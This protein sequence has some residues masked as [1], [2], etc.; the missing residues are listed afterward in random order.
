MRRL[1]SIL[2]LIVLF[3][4]TS[5]LA[6]PRLIIDPN[7][8]KSGEPVTV[9]GLDFCEG[10]QC[11]VV[12]VLL[13]DVAMHNKVPVRSGGVF[14]VEIEARTAPGLHSVRA[15]QTDEST[16]DVIESSADLVV[17]VGEREPGPAETPGPFLTG[18]R[19]PRRGKGRDH[20]GRLRRNRS[21]IRARGSGPD[22]MS[23]PA[24]EFNFTPDLKYGGRSVNA[25]ISPASSLTAIE[26]AEGSGLSRTSN[27]GATWSRIATF[28]MFRMEDVAYDPDDA[29]IVIA[30]TLHDG[31]V[32]SR[33]GIWQSTT[34][35]SFWSRSPVTYGCTSRPNSWG[36][37]T[38][39]GADVHQKIF[40]ANDCGVAY[41]NDSA[42][43]WNNIDPTGGAGTRF[44]D[45][46]ATRTGVD[47]VTAY[48]CGG[49][50][51]YRTTV[52]G[53]A[54]PSWTQVS[55]GAPLSD[56]RCMMAIS[57][58]DVNVVFLTI[59]SCPLAGS[60]TGQWGMRIFESDD[61]GASWNDLG[62]P[63]SSNRP[64]LVAA[65]PSI[66]AG[67]S[68]F[69]LY[70]GNGVVIYRQ[71]C[72]DDADPNTLDC[73]VGADTNCGD[74]ADDDGDG[75]VNEGCPAGGPDTD[76]NG[77]PDPESNGSTPSQC[78]NA[79]D[80]DGDGLVNDG[81]PIMER[82]DNGTHPD[83][84]NIAFDPATGCPT[85]ISNDGGI[86][87]STDCGLNWTDSNAGRRALQIYNT[88]GTVR[89]P[90]AAE[91]DIY[92]GTQ[93]NDWWFSL[94]NGGTWADPGCCEGF[95]GQADRRVP[96][97]GLA[98][99][100][101]TYKN[102]APFS[103]NLSPRGFSSFGGTFADPPGGN[104]GGPP[105]L[106]GNQRFAML[107][108]DR[109]CPPS[110]QLYIL[111][112]ETG[113]AC[114]NAV[115]DDADG[116]VNDGCPANGLDEIG[117]ACHNAVDDD[118]DGD[119]NDGCSHFF[120]A[121]SGA[122]CANSADDDGDGVV[123]D[124]CPRG[125]PD[126]DGDGR[127]DPEPVAANCGAATPGRCLDAVDDDGDGLVNDGC[128]HVGVW[129]AMG[130]TFS[131]AWVN[132][133]VAS[134]P[135][136]SP[137]FYFGVDEGGSDF[138]LRKISGPMN[139]TATLSDASGPPGSRLEDIGAFCGAGGTW[140]CPLVFEVNPA[141]PMHLIATDDFSQEMKVSTDGGTSWQVEPDLTDLVTLNGTFEWIA[142]G[143][144]QAWSIAWDPENT[145]RT[146][147]GTEQ[148]G[149]VATVDGG[150]NW[151]TLPG[152]TDRI[153]FVNSFFFDQ[154]HNLVFASTYGRGLWTFA[155]D[156]LPPVAKCKDVTVNTDPGLCSAANADIDDGSFDPDG[157]AVTLSQSPA[158][159][160]PLGDTLVTLTVTDPNGDS[161]SCQATVT[162]VDNEPPVVTCPV[163]ISVECTETGGTPATDPNLAPFFAGVSATDN[164]DASPDITND[165]P[166]FFPLGDTVV[167]FSAEDDSG[168]VGTC[169]AT[170]SVVDTTPPEIS[171]EVTPDELWPPR[172]KLVE[173]TATVTV[174]DI[175][176]PNPVVTLVSITSN[177]PDNGLG[178]GNTTGDI[179]DALF[180]TDD[181][182]FSL[183][184]ERAGGRKGRIYAILYS[185]TDCSNNVATATATVTVAHDRRR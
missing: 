85:L 132:P 105:T 73:P 149:I 62:G 168:N 91:T 48:A 184:A 135:V 162:V 30:S 69:D 2:A 109:Q 124:G 174:S 42:A 143:G 128:P 86:G 61:G 178:D 53:G 163:D 25:T 158:G 107:N 161:A 148:A 80:D 7:P 32:A 176:D 139:A 84:A 49:A 24:D 138:E 136:G 10:A 70:W 103:N 165:A 113:A 185:A 31:R 129:G 181:R 36:I 172:H 11:S 74:S 112:P 82:L 4:V 20:E 170:V 65:Q 164:C 90:G 13:D 79:A 47:T 166:P 66:G 159:P 35:G 126:T 97:G 100:R 150:V 108:Q 68:D 169:Q 57:P 137:T 29:S 19:D 44:F 95:R 81:C 167:T 106:F 182:V 16:G 41:T 51:V 26:A 78:K 154:D 121:E 134:G 151:F 177:E 115:D 183:R 67:A 52:T 156:D 142:N 179:Q 175:C 17:G 12:T 6:G 140:Y 116:A 38:A 92:F 14:A 119:V 104:A 43:N 114:S 110:Y 56:R 133:L 102:G 60:C 120:S 3:A 34:G 122:E 27:G 153:P 63:R 99:I 71:R 96:P 87:R 23:V 18:T 180:G 54:M 1:S 77:Q 89:G 145:L 98:D 55:S 46:V 117:T 33:G 75:I 130:P 45:V 59:R 152:T 123:N 88:W 144:T 94:D 83:P 141:N 160:Y 111:Q 127:P 76:G 8:A 5:A 58:F 39:A 72:T 9:H 171:V 22:I 37:G 50:G 147:V 28:P 125:G 40:A 93:D 101:L 173:V 157:G 155:L 15:F 131:N 64:G 118:G 21:T 146:V